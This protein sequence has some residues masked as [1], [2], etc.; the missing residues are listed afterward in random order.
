MRSSKQSCENLMPQATSCTQ[1]ALVKLMVV[2]ILIAMRHKETNLARILSTGRSIFGWSQVLTT[3]AISLCK[4]SWWHKMC[5]VMNMQHVLSA[6]PKLIQSHG[7]FST[8]SSP[9]CCIPFLFSFTIASAGSSWCMMGSICQQQLAMACWGVWW[10]QVSSW[11]L[12]GLEDDIIPY[13]K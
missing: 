10:S 11:N 12:R 13:W 5:H 1:P 4:Q 6:T 9:K 7:T 8:N 3:S 2:C